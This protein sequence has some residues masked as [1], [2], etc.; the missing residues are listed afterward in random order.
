MAISEINR[1]GS[2]SEP[3]KSPWNSN[4]MMTIAAARTLRDGMICF[5]GIGIPSTAA[6]LAKATHAP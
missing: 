5:V 1:A 3:E 4:E 2:S 6:I